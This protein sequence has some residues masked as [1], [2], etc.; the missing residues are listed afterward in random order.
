MRTV[1]PF[2]VSIPSLVDKLSSTWM[3]N[4]LMQVLDPAALAVLGNE[5]QADYEL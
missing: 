1:V 2:C 4:M 3:N 5:N